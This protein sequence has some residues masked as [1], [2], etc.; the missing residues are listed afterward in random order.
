M[1]TRLRAP[2]AAAAA[3]VTAVALAACGSSSGGVGPV[4][5]AAAP[6]N[7]VLK[8]GLY[9]DPGQPPDPDVFYAGNGLALTTNLYQGL[10]QYSDGPNTKIVPDLATSWSVNKTN[11]VF[12]FHLRHGVT[13]HDGTPFTSAAVQVDFERRLA[14]N[15]GPAYMAM[16]VKSFA[17]PNKYTS[18]ITLKAPNSAFLDELAS[19][20]GVR[21]ISP[22]GLAKHAGSNHAQTYLATHD[23]GTGPYTLTVAKV[24]SQYVMKAYPGYWGQKPTFTEIDL[25]VYNDSSALQLALNN[26]AIDA[27]ISALPS[28]VLGS[29]QHQAKLKVYQ[30]PTMQVGVLYMNPHKPFLATAAARKAMFESVDWKSVIKEIIPNTD[31]L[32]TGAYSDGALPPGAAPANITYDPSLLAKYVKTLPKGTTVTLGY[33]VGAEDDQHIDNLIAAQ[34]D[35]LGLKATVT[36]YQTSVI[37]GSWPGHPQKA[38]DLMVASSTWPDADNPYLYGHVFWDPNG[39]LNFMGCS[40]ATATKDLAAGLRTGSQADYV[41]AAKAIQA[42]EC[43]PIF[44]YASDFVIAQPWLAGIPAAHSSGEPY[45]LAFNKLTIAP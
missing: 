33:Q 2:L 25:I 39:G 44:A 32:A 14:V 7:G 38:P 13:F 4:S 42:T 23:L 36:G 27:V 8:V 12:T 15:G 20:Y 24:D 9:T 21:M 41:A 5:S 45:T 11:T 31:R 3:A 37:F 17:T 10:V 40:S 29:Y 19:P 34:L 26:G 30:L 1:I 16:G 6:T 18:V 28:S 35:A 43:T 22:T